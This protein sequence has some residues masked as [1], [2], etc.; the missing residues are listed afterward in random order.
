MKERHFDSI[1]GAGAYYDDLFTFP[2]DAPEF[3]AKSNLGSGAGNYRMVTTLFECPKCKVQ[4]WRDEA[5][6]WNGQDWKHLH[7]L[8][9]S[10]LIP[11]GLDMTPLLRDG[12]APID[13][14]APAGGHETA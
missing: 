13:S 2:V 7:K 10:I 14:L 4:M 11:E 6:V 3:A 12:A 1:D 9:R 8:E 5:A